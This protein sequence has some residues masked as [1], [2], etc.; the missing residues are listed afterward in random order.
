LEAAGA[1]DAGAGG[2]RGE[3]GGG[4]DSD[5]VLRGPHGAAGRCVRAAA[6]GAAEVRVG[7]TGGGKMARVVAA[8]VVTVEVD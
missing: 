6:A 7:A 5:H 8:T 4:W 3:A 2:G 1:G